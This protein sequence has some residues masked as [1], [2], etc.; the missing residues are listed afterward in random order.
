VEVNNVQWKSRNSL[1]LTKYLSVFIL[2][3]T[4]T[5]LTAAVFVTVVTDRNVCVCNH[6]MTQQ[7]IV[8]LHSV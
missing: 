3:P 4:A 1:K 7:C 8:L 5:S 6:L 2:C